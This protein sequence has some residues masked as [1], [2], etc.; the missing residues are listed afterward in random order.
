MKPENQEN[1]EYNFPKLAMRLMQLCFSQDDTSFQYRNE[2]TTT[3]QWL[4]PNSMVVANTDVHI[5]QKIEFDY[6]WLASRNVAAEPWSDS[7]IWLKDATVPFH[8]FYYDRSTSYCSLRLM[9][10]NGTCNVYQIGIESAA[11]PANFWFTE[12]PGRKTCNMHNDIAKYHI[13]IEIQ[14]GKNGENPRFVYTLT[15]LDH[16]HPLS[17]THTVVASRPDFPNMALVFGSNRTAYQISNLVV[18][19]AHVSKFSYASPNAQVEDP[20]VFGTSNYQNLHFHKEIELVLVQTKSIDCLVNGEK[21]HLTPNQLLLIN[22]NIHHQIQPCEKQTKVT[23]LNFN[24]FKYLEQAET[25]MSVLYA[26]L[27]KNH[28]K[29]YRIYAEE[30]AGELLQLIQNISEETNRRKPSYQLYLRSYLTWIGAYLS[31]EQFV[32]ESNIESGKKLSKIVP[33]IRYINEHFTEKITLD[34]ISRAVPID[35]YYLCKAFRTGTNSTVLD[36]INFLRLSHA[37]EQLLRPSISIY[38]VAYNSGF[39]SVP[40]FNRLFKQYYNC[41]PMEYRKKLLW[42]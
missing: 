22:S 38:E 35:K 2:Y 3:S 23:I 31:R 10:E 19:N 27:R 28:N 21:M 39:S 26:F 16:P 7:Y 41:T 4:S 29:P 30:E 13:A 6:E 1:I 14:P 37:V 18:G 25:D 12:R 17:Y 11:N 42:S 9:Y 34:Q 24:V 15:E 5:G 8:D 20:V 40:Y 32:T 33:A 36:Y